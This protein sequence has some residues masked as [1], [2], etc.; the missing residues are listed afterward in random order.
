MSL[1]SDSLSKIK[2]TIVSYS[3][4]QSLKAFSLNDFKETMHFFDKT[5]N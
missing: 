5:K 3:Q 1:P 4:K 2:I